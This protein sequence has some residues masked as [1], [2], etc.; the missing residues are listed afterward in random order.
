M[1]RVVHILAVLFVLLAPVS[2]GAT[3]KKEGT[4]PSHDHRVSFDF[5]GPPNEGLKELAKEAGWSLVV[6]KSVAMNAQDVHIDV[7]EQPA[8]AVL[9]A[10]FVDSN[11]VATRNGTLVTISNAGTPTTDTATPPPPVPPPAPNSPPPVPTVRGEDRSFMGS[12][13]TVEKDDVVHDLQVTGGS[14][15]IRGVVTGD[16]VVTGGSA[17]IEGTGRVV[18][19]VVVMG[20][21]VHLAKGSR[22]DGDVAT[23]GGSVDKDEGAFVGGD[24]SNTGK[25]KGKHGKSHGSSSSGSSHDDS[26]HGKLQEIGQTIS[27]MAL[28]FVFGCVL[29]ALATRRVDTLRVEVASRPMRSFALGI[30]GAMG[31]FVAV[32]VM[33]ITIVGIPFAIMLVLAGVL[34]TYGSIAAVLTTFGAAVIGHKSKSAYVHLLVGCLAFLILLPIPFVG[35]IV[36]F[37]VTMIAIGTLIATKIGSEVKMAPATLV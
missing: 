3:V 30:L 15:T 35:G 26:A 32:C 18:G 7:D 14:V 17:E 8:D 34:A 16:L 1:N 4:W 37:A 31:A 36:A 11:V 29:L 33:C 2:A 25:G 20:G 24:V 23:V 5:D 19:D 12:S 27:K 13:H 9:D 21:S 28:L 10:L 22:V 6:S